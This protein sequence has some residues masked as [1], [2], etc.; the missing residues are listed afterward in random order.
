[1]VK[2]GVHYQKQPIE[3]ENTNKILLQEDY[4]QRVLEASKINTVF[5]QKPDYSKINIVDGISGDIQISSIEEMSKYKLSATN[6][7]AFSQNTNF[8]G[9]DESKFQFLTLEGTA[10]ITSHSLVGY[11]GSDIYPTSLLTFYFYTRSKKILSSS[12]Y[13]KASE[14][15]TSDA[16]YDYVIDR[17]Q[18]IETSSIANSIVF[19]D[20]PIIGGNISSY[21]RNLVFS[22][23]KKN[24]IPIFFV[25][26]S[27]S[28]LV[29]NSS[30]EFKEKY[31]SDLHWSYQILKHGERTQLFRYTDK[32]NK[33]NSKLFCYIKPHDFITPQ[34]I[35]F[36]PDTYQ[37]YG[38]YFAEI[39]DLI[40][41]LIL[42]HGDI[43]NPQ[44]RPIAIAE[45][46]SR[47]VIRV[48]RPETILRNSSLIQTMDQ[49][50]FGG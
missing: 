5:T 31:N 42:A 21:T 23:H 30:L 18:I 28:N 24:I 8:A 35:E 20:G 3:F 37:I 26:N 19:I 10:N 29:I 1:M 50:R 12:K 46:Y 13:V 48:L 41:Y 17:N 33:E 34:R 45:K 9:Y 44:I 32:Y 43:N 38:D 2:F 39:F 49:S 7:F 11:Y 36:H 27:D 4:F 40:Y 6:G 15:P 47:E 14:D 16:N 25:K 22:L